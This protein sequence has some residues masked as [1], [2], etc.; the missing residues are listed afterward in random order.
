[1][2]SKKDLAKKLSKKS[3]LSQKEAVKVIEDLFDLITDELMSRR[4]C[5]RS[6]LWKILF[7]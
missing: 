5:L 2:I 6:R 1:M 7:I 3:Y 4:R